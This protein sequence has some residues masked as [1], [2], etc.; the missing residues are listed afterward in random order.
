MDPGALSV[1]VFTN[2]AGSAA[3]AGREY[4]RALLE[5]L[6]DR[7]P[8][9]VMGAQVEWLRDTLAGRPREALVR[10]ERPGKWSVAQVLRH[11]VDTEWVY[12]YPSG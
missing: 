7:D 2:P 4:T 10:P 12:G 1:S 6:G 5:L 11:L 9:A 3:E 8:R